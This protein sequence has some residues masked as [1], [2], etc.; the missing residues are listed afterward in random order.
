M[1]AYESIE[2]SIEDRL[3]FDIL[4]FDIKCQLIKYFTDLRNILALLTI[5]SLANSI[6]AC[7]TEIRYGALGYS[8]DVSDISFDL[9]TIL[10]FV[11]VEVCEVPIIV[12]EVSLLGSLGEHKTLTKF[13]VRIPN[14][15]DVDNINIAIY[16]MFDSFINNRQHILNMQVAI[17]PD[18]D[19][20]D[21]NIAP[22]FNVKRAGLTSQLVFTPIQT[23]SS[24]YSATTTDYLDFRYTNGNVLLDSK[25]CDSIIHMN[26][27]N[28]LDKSENIHGIILKNALSL[29]AMRHLSTLPSMPNIRHIY[30]DLI[31]R[32]TTNQAFTF[33]ISYPTLLKLEY[34]HAKMPSKITRSAQYFS[35]SMFSKV[36][37]N[38]VQHYRPRYPMVSIIYPIDSTVIPTIIQ[39]IP[40]I[41]RLGLYDNFNTIQELT[42]FVGNMLQNIMVVHIFTRDNKEKYQQLIARY[43]DNVVIVD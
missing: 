17:G 39:N 21:R 37:S 18:F 10:K 26:L 7:V 13:S 1:G 41:N 2:A 27:L 34:L 40:N 28:L 35:G 8:S 14:E 24:I 42:T 25:L 30:L 9:N 23:L 16:N 12:K 29:E 11:K 31:E 3:Y 32:K 20:M 43:G 4:P 36:L 15:K 6:Y 22:F 33:F 5:E 19:N 38:S